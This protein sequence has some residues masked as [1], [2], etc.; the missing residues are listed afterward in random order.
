M[1]FTTE[2]EASGTQQQ[3]LWLP[4]ACAGQLRRVSI[5]PAL[6]E[7]P[8]G[9][10]VLHLSLPSPTDLF[11]ALTNDV[12]RDASL[13]I[14]RNNRIR[15]VSASTGI[16]TTATGNGTGTDVFDDGG[17][18]TSA[19]IALSFTGAIAV[20]VAGNLFIADTYNHRMRK[21]SASTGIITT[22]AGNGIGAF[23]RRRAS[24]FRIAVLLN[25]DV[26]PLHGPATQGVARV[27]V[28]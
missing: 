22:V 9:A 7:L 10:P 17:P 24:H 21:V 6:P 28:H 4:L 18:A 3:V 15:K 19:P 13:L 20:D 8:T 23:R 27:S 26:E 2:Q 14:P 25:F 16:I 5:P 12:V 1:R 11:A